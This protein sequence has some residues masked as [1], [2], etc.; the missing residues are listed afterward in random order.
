MRASLS[1][2]H[3]VADIFHPSDP[4]IAGQSIS[5]DMPVAQARAFQF[6]S[7]PVKGVAEAALD[8]A[9]RTSTA[10]SCAFCEQGGHLAAPSSSCTVVF[11]VWEVYSFPTYSNYRKT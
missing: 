3:P 2:A 11:L 1:P 10:S 8:C 7:F 6:S 9:H 5:R 4:T